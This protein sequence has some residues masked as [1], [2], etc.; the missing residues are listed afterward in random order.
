MLA[1]LAKHYKVPFYI[2]APLST[3][4]LKTSDG[5]R[6]PIEERSSEEVRGFG[7]TLTAPKNVKVYNPAFDVTDHKLISAIITEKGVIKNPSRDSIGKCV[8]RY[9]SSVT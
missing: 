3:F 2:V 1:I 5:K 9:V 6:I 7:K 8:K 4:D